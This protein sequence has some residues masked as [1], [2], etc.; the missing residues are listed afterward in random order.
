M[1]TFVAVDIDDQKVLKSIENI[2]KNLKILAKPIPLNN[3]HFTLSFL[4]EISNEISKNIQEKLSSIEFPS[5]EVEIKGIGVFPKP[6]FPRIIWAGTD[7][8]GG[9][10]LIDLA[11]SVS[12]KLSELG[13]R[14]DKPFKPH[15]TIFRVKNKIANIS[16]DL[17]MYQSF[18][19]GSQKVSRIKFKQSVLDSKGPVYS[20][21]Q[22]VEAIQ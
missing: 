19:F 1:R 18:S 20:D 10:K 8:K 9:S 7:S 21:I 15:I 13:F 14:S 5:F 6:S 2:Q 12:E 11:S 4:G 22:V 17:K 16:D 3:I